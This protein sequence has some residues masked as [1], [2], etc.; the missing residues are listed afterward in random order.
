M[1]DLSMPMN[2]A[3]PKPAFIALISKISPVSIVGKRAFECAMGKN[4]ETL[5]PH[6]L[7]KQLSYLPLAHIEGHYSVNLD[8]GKNSLSPRFRLPLSVLNR[9][10]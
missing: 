5:M 3:S 6:K 4:F 7:L 10:D 9:C 8:D 2:N 1:I